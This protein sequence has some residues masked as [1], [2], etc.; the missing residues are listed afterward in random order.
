MWRPVGDKPHHGFTLTELV[1]TLVIML[2]LIVLLLP[3]LRST[4]QTRRQVAC[5][6]HLRQNGLATLVH[7]HNQ[8]GRFPPMF[9][10]F[11]P[12]GKG[13][14]QVSVQ[15]RGAKASGLA[16]YAPQ[17]LVCPSDESPGTVPVQR[18]QGRVQHQPMSYG[19]NIELLLQ[20]V[21]LD[22]LAQPSGTTILYDGSMSGAGTPGRSVQ[23]AYA[24]GVSFARHASEPRHEK[25]MNAVFADGHVQRVSAFTPDTVHPGHRGG[26]NPRPDWRRLP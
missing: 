26:K 19:Y 23:G 7:T 12:A 15:A 10:N 8:G 4:M 1:I 6:S 20:D 5:A 18:G 25:Q 2:L 16:A 24:G 22:K 9:F 11:S 13:Q 3:A 21:R 14:F 17:E